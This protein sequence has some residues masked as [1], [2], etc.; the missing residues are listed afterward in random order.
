M[1]KIIVTG[2]TGMIGVSLIEESIKNGIEV[3]AVVRPNTKN[4]KRLPI[5][6]LVK[7]VECKLNEIYKLEKELE[8]KYDTFY[9]FGWE[10]TGKKDRNNV[11]IQNQ[12]IQ[13]TLE[14]IQLAKKLECKTFI[15]A[16]SQAEYGRINTLKISS[17]MNVN[18]EIA[19]GICKYSAG[20]LGEILAKEIGI[21]YIWTR[22]FSV[23]GIYDNEETMVTSTLKKMLRGEKTVF[24]KSEQM[25]D[26]LYS[27]D[28]GRAF[29]LIGKKGKSNSIYNIGSGK[30]KALKDYIGEMRDEIN[31]ELKIGIG[32]LEYSL[33]QVMNLCADI[34]NLEKDTGFTPKYSFK[35]GVKETVNWIKN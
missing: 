5:S 16:G 35:E 17:E 7:I 15:G 34:S 3:V 2:S 28:A 27:K 23:Y 6:P 10:S 26:Y 1:K 18:P 31:P 11:L 8:K 14:A 4:I 13:S 29:Y 30:S 25:W 20:K 19:Y 24:T 22:I 9:H 33:N 32:E 12:N 21:E